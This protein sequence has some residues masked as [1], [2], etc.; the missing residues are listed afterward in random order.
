MSL[1]LGILV[2]SL[3]NFIFLFFSFKAVF[4]WFPT[5]GIWQTLFQVSASSAVG[6]LAAYWGL[7]IFSNLF[8]LHTFLGI[9][10]QG[11]FAGILGILAIIAVLWILRSSELFEIY[12]SFRAFFLEKEK[13][14]A[15]MVPA[16][17]PEKLL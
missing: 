11:F 4:G 2:G 8:N 12:H 13:S 6:G 15:D 9:F 17:E 1:A 5:R 16:P 14:K 7:N 3:F 10:L